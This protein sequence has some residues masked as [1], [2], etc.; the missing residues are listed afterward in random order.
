MWEGGGGG[1][2]RWGR[3]RRRR[4]T[5]SPSAC[6]RASLSEQ[7]MLRVGAPRPG[8]LRVTPTACTAASTSLARGGP[9]A[10]VDD[11]AVA[12]PAAHNGSTNLP[13]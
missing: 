6:Q 9:A 2:H 3:G 12:D 13:Q 7:L 5:C 8:F 1:G 11:A 4:R 10:A